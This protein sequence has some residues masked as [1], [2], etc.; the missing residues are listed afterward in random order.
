MKSTILSKATSLILMVGFLLLFTTCLDQNEQKI[1]EI[2]KQ[3]DEYSS[4]CLGEVV[5][6]GRLIALTDYNSINYFLYRG[7][8]MG[9]QYEKLK[10]LAD[11]LDVNLEVRVNSDL[12]KG[13]EEL[14]SGEVDLIAMGLT[15]TQARSQRINF[16]K[17]HSQTR[18]VLVQRKPV[19][20]RKMKT[21]DEVESHLIRS[22]LDLADHTVHVQKGSIFVSHL[23][24]LSNEIG[25]TIHIIQDN[26]EIEEL[27]TAVAEGEID[28]TVCDEHVGLVNEKYYSV[29]DVRTAVS[30]PQNI[31]WAVN[32]DCDSLKIEINNWLATFQ[33]SPAAAYIYNKY[34]QS[35]RHIYI[36]KSEYHSARGGKISKYDDII[37]EISA[38]NGWDW[39]LLASLIYQESRFHPDVRSWVGAFGIMQ[40]MPNTAQVYGVD[41]TSS[42][43]DQIAAGVKFIKWLDR[44]L[45]ESIDI[46][47]ERTKF[48][49]AAYNVGIAHVYDGRRLAIKYGKNPNVWTDNVDFFILHKSNPKYYRDSVVRYGY[50]RGEETY[51]FVKEIL[52]RYEHYKKV[53]EN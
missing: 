12:D 15:I 52:Y 32:K 41:S 34:F 53:F 8:P 47:E 37:K 48:I 51:N 40:L 26:R 18:Q 27:I 17:P 13:F 6:R 21:W 31:A 29:L 42:V 11:Y 2:L 38:K 44:Q 14:N 19:N 24:S 7:E 43:E 49:L 22:P 3:E 25:D 35:S 28:Y 46:P 39:R 36:A 20:W 4:S 1:S 33:E 10:L 30:F 23:K 50:A 16:T 5:G 45:P 9:Y